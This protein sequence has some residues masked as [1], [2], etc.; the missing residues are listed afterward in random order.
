M[1]CLSW[2]ALFSC[3]GNTRPPFINLVYDLLEDTRIEEVISISFS[4]LYYMKQ[5]DF[6]LSCI[7][8][9][10]ESSNTKYS[11]KHFKAVGIKFFLNKTSL[12]TLYVTTG[13]SASNWNKRNLH[14]PSIF[15][16]I[17]KHCA[18]TKSRRL[19]WHWKFAVVYVRS[20]TCSIISSF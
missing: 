1:S 3:L 15:L 5:I 17:I 6:M 12:C 8:L 14:F 10:W 2:N 19:N 9:V 4:F 13:L 20:L 11:K 7:T 18:P 16:C